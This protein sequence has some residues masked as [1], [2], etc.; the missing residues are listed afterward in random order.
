MHLPPTVLPIQRCGLAPLACAIGSDRSLSSG[1][2]PKQVEGPAE[3][4]Q[5]AKTQPDPERQ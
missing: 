1:Q 3:A 2:P 4:D 5:L